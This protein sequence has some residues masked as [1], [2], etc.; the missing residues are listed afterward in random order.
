MIGNAFAGQAQAPS[1][2][3]LASALG[4]A[5][6]HWERLTGDLASEFGLAIDDWHS[7]SRKAGW[8]LRVKK[9]DRNIVYLSPGAGAFMASFALGDKAMA[10][11]RASKLPKSAVAILD[12]ARR[13]AE[14][15]AVRI[16]VGKAADLAVV[17]KLVAAK[18]AG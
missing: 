4:P 9:G 15:T 5:L 6:A 11:A 14:G 10:V 1:G 2:D 8:S 3:Q 13:Y 12:T 18:L 7:Y 16:D 17:R